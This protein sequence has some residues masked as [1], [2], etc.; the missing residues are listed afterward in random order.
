MTNSE[1]L[2]IGYSLGVIAS[3]QHSAGL[4]G[5]SLA[6]DWIRNEYNCRGICEIDLKKD[7]LTL[8]IDQLASVRL[9]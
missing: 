1:V 7:G 4:A 5:L 3:S 9:V 8:Y 2:E 6:A